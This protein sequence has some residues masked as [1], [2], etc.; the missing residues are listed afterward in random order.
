MCC[1]SANEVQQ[2][3]LEI[4]DLEFIIQELRNEAANTVVET[5]NKNEELIESK[6]EIE[7]LKNVIKTLKRRND[8]LIKYGPEKKAKRENTTQTEFRY[9]SE[10]PL[11]HYCPS[12]KENFL[13]AQ[14]DKI[15]FGSTEMDNFDI[16]YS[17]YFFTDKKDIGLLT[18]RLVTRDS[19][20]FKFS[21]FIETRLAP[22]YKIQLKLERNTK[23]RQ[24]RAITNVEFHILGLKKVDTQ[25][26]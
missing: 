25:C 8:Y 4:H 17:N 20:S 22:K 9:K 26:Y 15:V 10:K 19:D 7:T 18:L 2:L 6:K 1:Q 11:H 12:V 23:F 21:I 14:K 16:Y 3:R 5:L 13:F 24:N